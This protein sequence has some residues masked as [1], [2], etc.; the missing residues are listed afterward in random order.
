M[1]ASDDSDSEEG[2]RV[3]PDLAK[4]LT[5]TSDLSLTRGWSGAHTCRTTSGDTV[6][7]W[8]LTGLLLG[9]KR[10]PSRLRF[11]NTATA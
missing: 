4:L 2:L 6:T 7:T 9:V 5:I 11:S 10:I 3:P 8:K 1:G